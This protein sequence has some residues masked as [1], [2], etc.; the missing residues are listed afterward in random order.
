MCCVG[1]RERVVVG[2]VG[3]RERF[4]CEGG[5]GGGGGYILPKCCKLFH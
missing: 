1:I 5:G 2:S 3:G 4:W